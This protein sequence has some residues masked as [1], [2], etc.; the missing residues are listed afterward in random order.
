MHGYFKVSLPDKP[1]V[2]IL[3]VVFNGES[4]LEETIQSIIHQSYDNVEYIIID[5]GSTDGSLDIIRKYQHAI[6]YWVSEKD[7]G[8]YDAMNKGIDLATGKWVNFMN[9][10]DWLF[11]HDTLE[12]LLPSLTHSDA[13]IMYANHEVRYASGRKRQ[14]QAGKTTNLWKGSQ[15]CHQAAFVST[16]FHKLHKFNLCNR[17]AADFEFFFSAWKNKAKFISE[18]IT[19]CS[20]EAGGVSDTA[21]V[22][23]ILSFWLIAKKSLF[24]NCYYLLRIS[25]EILKTAIKNR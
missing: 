3:T 7:N 9:A 19:A 15:F 4:V 22:D 2:T 12:S 5:G 10:G 6:D 18:P 23:V 16:R 24:V 13:E 14:A 1:L 17:I 25:T 21:R 8:I 20:I 11:K